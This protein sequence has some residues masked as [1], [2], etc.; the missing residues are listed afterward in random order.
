MPILFS[1]QEVGA[2]F[3]AEEAIGKMVSGEGRRMIDSVRGSQTTSLWYCMR[4][5]KENG[6]QYNPCGRK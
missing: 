1:K 6:P 5:E 3:H 4:R 2:E